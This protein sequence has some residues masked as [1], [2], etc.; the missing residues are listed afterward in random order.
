MA[1]VWTARGTVA[2]TLTVSDPDMKNYPHLFVAFEYHD[3]STYDSPVTPGAGSIT[4][5]GKINGSGGYSSL[6]TTPID[7]TDVSDTDNGGAPFV[8]IQAVPTGITVATHYIM[9]VTANEA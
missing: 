9:T 3:A 5:S 1:K 8:S 4:V 7:C 2:S 6:P